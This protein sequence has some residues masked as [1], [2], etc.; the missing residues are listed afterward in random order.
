VRVSY[1]YGFSAD[2]GGGE[3]R[4]QLLTPG[5]E[6]TVYRVGEGQPFRRIAD[7]LT[8]WTQEKPVSAIIEIANSGVYVE[9][10]SIQLQDNQ[11]LQLRAAN[12]A[13]PVLRMIDWQTDLPDGLAITLGAGSC[14][15]LDGLIVTGRPVQIRG[16]R[17]SAKVPDICPAQVVIR[18]CTLVPGWGIDCGCNPRRP[19]EPSLELTDVR[20][21]VCIEHSIV[22]AIQIHENEVRLEP[23]PVAI[24]DSIIDATDEGRQAIGAPG[25]GIAHTTLTVVRTTVFGIVDVHA[26]QLGENS[27]FTSCVNV[28][29]RQIGCMRFCYVPAGCRTPRRYS[30]QPDGVIAAV[31]ERIA[32]PAKGASEIA[33]EKQRV[34]PQFNADLYGKPQYAQLA[35]TCAVEIVR[36]ADDGSEMGAF[37]DLF[38]PL[39]EANL[40]AR[41][42]EYT[43][44]DMNVGIFFAS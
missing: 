30:C 20:S 23:I 2:M 33:N 24:S 19:A 6:H 14:F 17:E 4:R 7:A 21:K 36:G 44:A 15:T 27:L 10:L 25:G 26:M 38:Q 28:A 16:A 9:P 34:R 8:R 41:L 12:R 37:H 1:H 11:R 39:R 42:D 32:D 31:K 18:H 13:R 35:E 29:R 3:Y 5:G 43:P 22:G 40:R